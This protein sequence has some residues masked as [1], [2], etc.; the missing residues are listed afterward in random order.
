MSFN[1]VDLVQCIY[2]IALIKK[3]RW[4]PC[5]LAE[6]GCG[7]TAFDPSTSYHGAMHNSCSARNHLCE[8]AYFILIDV[9]IVIFYSRK[10]HSVNWSIRI[11]EWYRTDARTTSWK[12]VICNGQFMKFI[13]ICYQWYI[14]IYIYAGVACYSKPHPSIG[15]IKWRLKNVTKHPI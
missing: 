4:I 12:K 10:V 3:K 7:A 8:L 9:A 13:I 1:K 14:Y 2:W 5:C 11:P 6:I 15:M